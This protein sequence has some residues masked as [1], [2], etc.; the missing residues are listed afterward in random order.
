MMK[1]LVGSVKTAGEQEALLV[2]IKTLLIYRWR[3]KEAVERKGER[4]KRST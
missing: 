4:G 1:H 3:L 2:D